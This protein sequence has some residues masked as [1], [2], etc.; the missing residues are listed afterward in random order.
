MAGLP[1]HVSL[2]QATVIAAA[3]CTAGFI[4]SYRQ[5]NS[6]GKEDRRG[7]AGAPPGKAAW[8]AKVWV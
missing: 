6:R 1:H 2:K 3:F 4:W 8:P 5:G 7:D